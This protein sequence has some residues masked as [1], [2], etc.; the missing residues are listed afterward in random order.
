MVRV[1]TG[2]WSVHPLPPVPYFRPIDIAF[3]P[4]DGA[5]HVL[6]FGRFEMT[7]RGVDAEPASGG[8][9]RLPP[10]DLLLSPGGEPS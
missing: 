1:D 8:L 3:H 9:W 4:D 6:D 10:L 7:D 2:D 5:L